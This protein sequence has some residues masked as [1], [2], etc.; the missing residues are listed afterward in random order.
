MP[1][2]QRTPDREPQP[3]A[4]RPTLTEFR[5]SSAAKQLVE[6][7]RDTKGLGGTAQ[8]VDFSRVKLASANEGGTFLELIDLFE[9][10]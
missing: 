1:H 6:G 5:R 3:T 7:T 8:E 4:T 2:R 10:E 9:S